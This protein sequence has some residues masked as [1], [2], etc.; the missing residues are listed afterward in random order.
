MGDDKDVHK[1]QTVE[2]ILAAIRKII[3]EEEEMLEP[4]SGRD[5]QQQPTDFD[6]I[7]DL[8]DPLPDEEDGEEKTQSI[9]D[10]ESKNSSAKEGQEEKKDTLNRG[11]REGLMSSD[12]AA[13]S[14]AALAALG[15]RDLANEMKVGGNNSLEDLVRD[16]L[17][18][19]LKQWLDANLPN[20]VETLVREEI[21]RIR[22]QNG[23]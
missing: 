19:M 15:N 10:S 8:S 23:Q 22:S 16:L 9:D 3:S 6:D 7:L 18:P 17:K 2:E 21:K 4:V 1:E 14:A 20:M 13:I 5:H 12:T 11:V